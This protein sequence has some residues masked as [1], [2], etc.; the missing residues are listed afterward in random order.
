MLTTGSG[1]HGFTLDPSLGEFILTHPD[2][3][4]YLLSVYSSN[5]IIHILS[6]ICLLV[7][8]SSVILENLLVDKDLE[9]NLGKLFFFFFVANKFPKELPCCNKLLSSYLIVY[10][11]IKLPMYNFSSPMT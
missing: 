8:T 7:K 6:C 9:R 5:N 11:P 2:I 3:K 10:S 4:V 1:V